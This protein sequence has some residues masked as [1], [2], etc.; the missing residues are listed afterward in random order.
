MGSVRRLRVALVIR[1][2][3]R[4]LVTARRLSRLQPTQ[5]ILVFTPVE[6]VQRQLALLWGRQVLGGASLPMG[7]AEYRA[8]QAGLYDGPTRC[9][10]RARN[11]WADSAECD[12]AFLAGNGEVRAE[13]LGVSLVRR[14]AGAGG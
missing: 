12:I 13:L 10:L 2:G 1:P 8:Y 7:V 9:V 3:P 6:Q 4:S 14:P 11:V 5:R